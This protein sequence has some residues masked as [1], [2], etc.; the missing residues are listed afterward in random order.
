[1][2]SKFKTSVWMDISILFFYNF[3]INSLFL[4]SSF[5]FICG[6]ISLI[7]I[8]SRVRRKESL[9]EHLSRIEMHLWLTNAWHLAKCSL[10]V[11]FL[12][13][14]S[15]SKM[16]DRLT[17]IAS[18]AA[19]TCYLITTRLLSSLSTGGFNEGITFFSFCSV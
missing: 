3:I 14:E 11:L 10:T 4:N 9:L 19:R 17:D 2:K 18:C 8:A 5:V 1:M 12:F 15:S 13:T 6:L 7:Q 16:S